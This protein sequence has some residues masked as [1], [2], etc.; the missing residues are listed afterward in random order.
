M[1]IRGKHNDDGY[2]DRMSQLA[3]HF[4]INHISVLN[5]AE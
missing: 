5:V 2:I 4:V 1:L 3:A